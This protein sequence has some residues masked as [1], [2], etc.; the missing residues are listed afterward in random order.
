MSVRWYSIVIDTPDP[1]GL[2]TW[3]SKTLGWPVIYEGDGE[4]VVSESETHEP[5][6]C[7]VKVDDP[8]TVKNRLHI[9]LASWP[10]D[11][12][13]AEV[14]RLLDRGATR[15]DVGQ[16]DVSWVVLADPEGNEFCVLT[17]RDV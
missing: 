2:A 4:A 6:L 3:W 14:Q 11:D 5:G 8:K 12:Q 17:P 9:D 13:E 15:V 7:F 16:G 1:L 10:D